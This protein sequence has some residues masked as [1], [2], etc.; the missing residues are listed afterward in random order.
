MLDLSLIKKWEGLR[1][2]AYRDAVG[3]PTIGYGNTFYRNGNKVRMGDRL[4]SEK[5][6]TKL[7]EMVVEYDFLPVLEKRIPTWSRMSHWQKSAV[8]TFAYNLGAH[9]YGANG[10]ASIT[11]LLRDP[12]SWGNKAY[13]HRIFGLYSRA[14]G[15]RLKG[16]VRRRTDE[17]NMFCKAGAAPDPVKAAPKKV[18][19]VAVQNT[20]LKKKPLDSSSPEHFDRILIQAG[21]K[22]GVDKFLAKLNGHDQIQLAWGA[23]NWWIYP[24]HW[25][26]IEA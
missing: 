26:K 8:L 19:I 14:G 1:L 16:L 22:F 5:E 9:F 7:L 13:V 21:Q 25:Q 3:I 23:G 10:F 12:S 17:A 4:S 20:L 6:A 18:F 2:N 15:R 24:P 11:K